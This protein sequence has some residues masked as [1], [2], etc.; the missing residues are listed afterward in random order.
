MFNK[1]KAPDIEWKNPKFWLNSDILT[2]DKLRGKIILLDFWTYSCVNCIRTLPSLK[3]IWKKYKGK[4]FMLIGI[5]T[6]EFE[7]EKEIGNVKYAIKK[8]DI[9]WPVLQDSERI[10]WE[11]YGNTYWPRAALINGEG[12]I[13]FE[14]IGESGYEDIDSKITEELNKLKETF[15]KTKIDYKQE[16]KYDF[17]TSREI[18]AG[19]LRNN[20]IGSGKVCTKEGCDEYIDNG[21]NKRD[22]IYLQ[23]D[24]AQESEFLEFKSKVQRGHIALRYYALEVNAVISGFGKAEV[25]LDDAPLRKSDAGKDISFENEKSYIKVEG[26]DMYNLIKHPSYNSRVLK[27]LPFEEMKVY[28]Y[29]FG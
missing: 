12:E 25:L 2:I 28:A 10:N 5:H 1:K 6:P 21:D 11:N 8:Y 3:S 14:H 17:N 26:A 27:I 13:I 9:D 29:T 23:G 20:G 7:F 4:R 22:L 18:Y 15:D 16:R 19:S 24:W